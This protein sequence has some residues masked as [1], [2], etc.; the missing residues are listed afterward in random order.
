M[1]IGV[2]K[3][4]PGVVDRTAGHLRLCNRGHHFVFCV[5]HRPLGQCGVYEL[6]VLISVFRAL[7]PIVRQKVLAA[8][9]GRQPSPMLLVSASGKDVRV[10]IDTAWLARVEAAGRRA[11]HFIAGSR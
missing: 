8:N 3:Q 2:V 10:I 5:L 9:H 7:K 1:E 4:L 6:P 11:H